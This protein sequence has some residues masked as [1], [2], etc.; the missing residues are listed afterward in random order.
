[1]YTEKKM[2]LFQVV[3]GKH[4]AFEGSEF[5]GV[6][7]ASVNAALHDVSSG[8]WPIPFEFVVPGIEFEATL[9]ASDHP[10]Y[11]RQYSARGD[12]KINNLR[13][14]LSVAAMKKKLTTALFRRLKVLAHRF[15]AEVFDKLEG[16]A[17]EA[18]S[19]ESL[20]GGSPKVTIEHVREILRVLDDS[21][22]AVNFTETFPP[23]DTN[24]ALKYADVLE[25][26]DVL[27]DPYVLFWRKP[28][29]RLQSNPLHIADAVAKAHLRAPV[30][31]DDPRRLSAYFEAAI[32]Q[33]QR[34]CFED[35]NGS[36]WFPRDAVKATMM[37]LQSKDDTEWSF[38]TAALDNMFNKKPSF[39][40][41]E[42]GFI[43]RALDDRVE[44][45]L[46]GR[47]V[48]LCREDDCHVQGMCSLSLFARLDRGDAAAER[49]L[50]DLYTSWRTVYSLY[51]NCDEMQKSTLRVLTE[52]RVL[53][54]MGGAGTGKSTTLAMIVRFMDSILKVSMTVCALTG[55]AVDRMKQ[56]FG[57]ESVDCRTL[58]S[59]AAISENQPAR[60]LA[61][62]EASMAFPGILHKI[63]T[64]ELSYLVI[65]GD[66]KQLPSID[67]GAFLRDVV[68]ADILPLVRL[69]RVYRTGDGSG[70]ATEAPK[71][72][73][74][75]DS[76]LSASPLDHNGFK[77]VLECD[78]DRA[79]RDFGRLAQVSSSKEVVM[80]S[81]TRRTCKNANIELQPI[82]NPLAIDPSSPK[83]SRP[84]G[85]APW[86]VGDRVISNENIDSERGGRIFNGMIGH[87]KEL[88]LDKKKVAVQFRDILHTFDAGD[89]AID[90][91]YC[92]TTWK[93]QG[94]EIS[95][96]IVFFESS[97]GLSCE[98]F[99]TAVTRG[100]LST[101]VYLTKQHLKY[102]LGTRLG[103][104]RVTF[105]ATRIKDL[106]KKR[107]RE[108]AQ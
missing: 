15:G 55:K 76:Q 87:V 70:I 59:Q 54:L 50:D 104:K 17:T 38:D 78:L 65:C 21:K 43:A 62:D 106:D 67:P 53:V 79:V 71:I 96:A 108:R 30:L 3:R 105:L 42:S 39:I 5:K 72:F 2:T 107:E 6:V 99:Y 94:S 66:D 45:S 63:I 93:F 22:D 4:K 89:Y 101:T 32:K 1:M 31:P 18:V 75:G 56:L 60:A 103:P 86:L 23:I 19:A 73:L 7:S 51:A 14:A 46:A 90:H 26:E 95:H 25:V 40:A 37:Q 13:Y 97:W 85:A 28:E 74:D 52:K 34:D 11:G 20:V 47:L 64:S 48:A 10:T 27:T 98:L 80:I 41:E 100:Q 84:G 68:A 36:F 69:E 88:D 57:G 33:L 58:H 35:T 77:I 29:G 81:N 83:L 16:V 91:A 44:R 61:I 92:V 82:C 102:A 49:E 8:L 9:H 24:T 12:I